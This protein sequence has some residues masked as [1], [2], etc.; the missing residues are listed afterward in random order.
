MKQRANRSLHT[1]EERLVSFERDMDFYMEEP[2]SCCDTCI[3]E[4]EIAS[5]RMCL[6]DVQNILPEERV[7]GLKSRIFHMERKLQVLKDREKNAWTV[8]LF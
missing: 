4:E 5:C 8:S 3:F 2:V 1:W 7:S 6:R